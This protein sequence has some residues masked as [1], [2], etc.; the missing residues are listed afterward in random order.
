[1]PLPKLFLAFLKNQKKISEVPFQLFLFSA[2]CD[3]GP[4]GV[5]TSCSVKCGLGKRNR[6]RKESYLE[7]INSCFFFLRE[8][9][10]D[11]KHNGE[12]C[13]KL[14][15]RIIELA[16]T[17]SCNVA[18]SP[19]GMVRLLKRITNVL[20]LNLI[21][22]DCNVGPWGSWTPCSLSCGG[23]IKNRTRCK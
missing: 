4:W 13:A 8:I 7:H 3:V 11:A 16:E 19:P 23:G 15:S 17:D 20:N 9:I 14:S 10:A 22:V 5:W 12:K 18:C 21:S 1:M 2:D 6:T